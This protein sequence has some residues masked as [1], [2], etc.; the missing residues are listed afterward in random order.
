MSKRIG[1]LLAL[2]GAIAPGLASAQNVDIPTQPRQRAVTVFGEEKCPRSTDPNEIIICNHRPAEEQ[3]R[4]PPAIRSQARIEK[5][6]DVGARIG[7]ADH[8]M[9]PVNCSAV[10][11]QG[12][13]GCSQGLNILGA[14]RKVKEAVTG[15]LVPVP[16]APPQ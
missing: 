16:D 3:F 15:D 12:Q 7:L 1:L 10:G 9:A 14:A 5:R 6:D 13:F 8:T 4:I 2:A 11:T